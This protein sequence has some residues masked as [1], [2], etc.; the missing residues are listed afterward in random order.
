MKCDKTRVRRYASA[1]KNAA[2][3]G[4]VAFETKRLLLRSWEETD[5]APFA[6]MNADAQVMRYFPSVLTAD[7]RDA[8][9]E[10]IHLHFDQH[11]FGLWAVALKDWNEFAG[12]IGLTV[13]SFEAHFT[14]CIEIGW[15]LAAR[16]WNRGLATEG[17][18]AVL[19]FAHNN[20][21]LE[22]I[23]SFTVV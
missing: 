10:R 6:K 1:M 18:A 13:P 5:R 23:V 22:Q 4:S 7:E 17:A 12:F 19:A 20:L 9:L 14:P 3:P 8:Y 16:F 11:G 21:G 15:R 2:C